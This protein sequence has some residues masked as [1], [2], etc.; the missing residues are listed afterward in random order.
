MLYFVPSPVF[1]DLAIIDVALIRADD[2]LGNP[3]E[4]PLS[5]SFMMDRVPPSFSNLRPLAEIADI[6][7]RVSLIITDVSSGVNPDS[8]IATI[9]STD[10]SFSYRLTDRSF[11]R[12]DSVYYWSSDSASRRFAG[13]DT[14]CVH[15]VAFDRADDFYGTG[16]YYD[17]ECPPNSNDTSWCFVI[18]PGG[19]ISELFYP[20]TGQWDACNPDTV[21]LT[22]SDDDTTIVDS[23]IIVWVSR[24]VSIIPVSA[25]YTTDSAQIRYDAASERIIYYPD[26]PFRNGETVTIAVTQ[27]YDALLNPLSHGDTLVFRTD[28]APP[29]LLSYSPLSMVFVDDIEP[30]ISL[31][32]YDSLSG[33][34]PSEI[35]LTINGIIYSTAHHAVSY[36]GRNLIYNPALEPRY[37]NGGD[38]VCVTIHAGDS[39]D[40][41]SPNMMD[42]TWCFIITP[43]GP[44]PAIVRAEPNAVSSC[45]DEIIRAMI[46]DRDGI[47]DSTILIEVIRNAGTSTETAQRFTVASTELDYTYPV[48][49]FTPN[50][51]FADGES[52]Y[53]SILEEEDNLRNPLAFVLSWGFS[54]D[55]TPPVF[56]NEYPS[57]GEMLFTRGTPLTVEI[58]DIHTGV[59]ASSIMLLVVNMSDVLPPYSFR[60]GESGLSFDSISGLLMLHID[61]VGINFTGGD[62][63]CVS[64]SAHDRPTAY[65][66]AEFLVDYCDPNTGSFSW[67]FN[68]CSR[69]TIRHN[70][71]TASQYMVIMHG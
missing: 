34:N 55:L 58:Q 29:V 27:A 23:S 66:G 65:D 49:T 36:D 33:I 6:T 13:G 71:K 45:P 22:L 68:H 15:V 24:P 18:T 70:T 53:V 54:M 69:R 43:G 59:E 64:V 8:V 16:D 61:S 20:F 37:F 67:C 42:S 31:A 63:V 26:P 4:T 19:P 28:Y 30:V 5:W 51:A 10:G 47:A 2:W 14:V 11:W 35:R 38:T 21:V 12:A 52:I 46:T 44:L 1:P 56:L 32:I 7:P 62:S 48:L 50:P 40:L 60:F 57:S 17:E 41:C 25:F 39:P 9:S 3:L